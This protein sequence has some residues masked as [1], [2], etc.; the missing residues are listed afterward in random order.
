MG[1]EFAN[2]AMLWGTALAALPLLVHLFNRRRARPHPFAAIDFVLRSR[3]RTARRLRLKRL[4]LFLVR[5]LLLLAIPLALARPSQ[6]KVDAAA[7][8]R[9][10]AATALVLDTSLSMSYLQGGKP[11]LERAKAMSRE[12]LSSLAVED[13]VTLVTCEPD[14][15]PPAPPGFDRARVR[16]AIDQAKPTLVPQDLTACVARA[17]RVLAESPVVAKRLV[18]ATD[19]T[20][21]A[22]R[23]DVPAPTIPTAQGEVRPEV[24]LLDAAGGAELPNA[25]ITSLRVEAAPAIGHRAFQFTATIANHSRAALKDVPLVLRVGRDVV[26]KGFVDVP[27]RGTAVKTLAHRFP[28]GGV[29]TGVMELARDALDADD[30]RHF[31][32][33]V[34]RDVRALV[35]DGEPNPVRFLDEAFFVEAALSSPGSPV[36]PTVRDAETAAG[37]SFADYDVFLLLN[38]RELPAAKV[39]E[40]RERVHA[41]AGLFVS[42]GPQV[43]GDAYNALFGDLLPR[44]LHLVK[45]AAD[46][47]EENPDR[48]PARLDHVDF[49]HPALSVFDGEAREGMLSARTFRYFLLSPGDATQVTTLASYDDG[50]PALLEARRQKGRVLLYTSTV[51][52]DW[53]DWAIRS[54]FLPALQRLTGWLAGVLDEKGLDQALVGE[55]KPLAPP[56]GV[57]PGALQVTGPDERPVTVAAASDGQTLAQRLPL[58]GVYKVANSAPL[59]ELTFTANVDPRESDLT[60]LEEPE[61]KVYFG[62]KTR[63]QKSSG[64]DEEPP[65]FPLWSLL[66]AVA[67]G[68]VMTEGAL[69]RL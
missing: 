24:V 44:P 10:P 7:Q 45:T 69:L 21:A 11:L 36:R 48:K 47:A 64:K 30:V 23:L 3:R 41:G 63:T 28:A 60:R 19:L 32:L 16:E 25:A 46:R 54:S 12:A 40:L 65:P 52:R 18:L 22:F 39:Q 42:L 29:F 66:L 1:L 49:E 20:A 15:P 9:G 59:P 31:A 38:V 68:L 6:R 55:D 43:D 57:K 35:V 5:T 14:A 58:A 37:E 51:D 67:A 62:E 8:P 13:P 53:S 50:A 34:P 56:P 26:A 4:A 33:R 17:A 27:P 2:P 61:L